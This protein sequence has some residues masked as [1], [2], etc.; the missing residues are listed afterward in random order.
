MQVD[1]YLEVAPPEELI[2]APPKQFKT[3]KERS[4]DNQ[5]NNL[6]GTEL[7]VVFLNQ[8][9]CAII[10]TLHTFLLYGTQLSIMLNIIFFQ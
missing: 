4:A 8:H 7:K 5:G 6:V 9:C 10:S 1:K 3:L 2:V